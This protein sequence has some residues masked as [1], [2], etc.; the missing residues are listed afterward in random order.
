VPDTVRE[1]AP[2]TRTLR[3]ASVAVTR[4]AGIA[5]PV[6]RELRPV[7]PLLAPAL[8]AVRTLTPQV[9]G[10]L[11]DLDA[12]LPVVAKALP[13]TAHLVNGLRPFTAVLYPATREITPIIDIVKRYR[14][15]LIATVANSAAANQATSPGINGEPAHY[16]RSM[17]PVTEES[18]VGY[19]KRLPSNRHN[20]YFAPGELA[21]L[22]KGGLLAADC[23]NTANP[24]L[25]PVIGSGAPPCK[26]QPP[27]R[28]GG[29]TR[30]FPHVA[31]VPER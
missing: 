3:S 27:W 30:Y 9:E 15:E 6:L 20:A 12:A 16:L 19:E 4:T 23:R 22:K 29:E 7:A 28:F 25:V 1:L 2:L 8:D 31:R 18:L 10:V 13:A 5:G 17:V 14:R 24:Q 26:L 21:N 11:G